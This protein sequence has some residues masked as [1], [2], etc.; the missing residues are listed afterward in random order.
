MSGKSSMKSY[1]CLICM[2]ARLDASPTW[3]PMERFAA[4]CFIGR[5]SST[6]DFQSFC[7]DGTPGVTIGMHASHG[8]CMPSAQT[9]LESRDTGGDG[10]MCLC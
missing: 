6:E 4:V 2:A 7:L 1:S 9:C 10:A 8:R 5:K 3:Y